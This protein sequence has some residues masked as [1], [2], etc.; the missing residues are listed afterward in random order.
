MARRYISYQRMD[1]SSQITPIIKNKMLINLNSYAKNITGA[2]HIGAH[3]GE[4]SDWYKDNSIHP[5][6]WIEANPEY[7]TV[8]QEKSSPEDLI[9]ISAI[10][11]KNCEIDFNISNNGQSSSVLE[12]G[13]HLSLHPDVHYIKRITVQMNR[14]STIIDTYKINMN[15]YNFLNI[16]IQG[17]ELEAIKSF[18]SHINK[19]Q[20]IYSEINTNYVYK[21]CALINELDDYLHQHKFERT[22]TK[23]WNEWGDALYIKRD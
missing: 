12:L 3:K 17:Y 22:L 10:G 1:H 9:I 23:M 6:V 18:D 16:D 5:I 13:T 7:S 19:F 15:K 11:N 20:Y 4:E 14:M 21:N 2:I 8:L